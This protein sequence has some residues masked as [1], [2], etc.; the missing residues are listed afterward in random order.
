M[1]KRSGSMWWFSFMR[2][3]ISIDSESV[4]PFLYG[5]SLAVSA[6]KM[7]AMPMQRQHRH[8]LACETL[9]VALAVH[10]LVVAA[11]VLRHVGEV[12]GPGQRLEHANRGDDVVVD[13]LALF[14]GE[15]ARAD[16]EIL[17][18]VGA[19]EIRLVPGDVAP[20][21]LG[22]ALHVRDVLVAHALAA[23]VAGVQ[24]LAVFIEPAQLGAKLRLFLGRLHAP[25]A[26]APPERFDFH[27]ALE[28]LE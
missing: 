17:Y 14:L 9:R 2:P 18:L 23:D 1:S 11:G 15:R 5:L 24:E 20:A 3:R 8:L 12:L 26:R 22:D 16:G 10:A 6:S 21:V 19:E 25:E 4:L 27:V 28:H 13:D 7:S